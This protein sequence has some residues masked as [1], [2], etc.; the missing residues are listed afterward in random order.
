MQVIQFLKYL[1]I[2]D[3]CFFVCCHITYISTRSTLMPQ[4]SVASS[5]CTWKYMKKIKIRTN[6]TNIYNIV[7][8]GKILYLTEKNNVGKKCNSIVLYC[9][10]YNSNFSTYVQNMYV[11]CCCCRYVLSIQCVWRRLL[12][13][14]YSWRLWEGAK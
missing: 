2:L 1:Y 10:K 11:M 4:A 7:M 9:R 14:K 8:K 13:A 5:N 6:T 3:G 12:T